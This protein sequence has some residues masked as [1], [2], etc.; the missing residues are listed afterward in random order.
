M[1]SAF[2]RR[3]TARP[4]SIP[5]AD[6]FRRST[7]CPAAATHRVPPE[8]TR[9]RRRPHTT[10][11]PAGKTPPNPLRPRVCSSGSPICSRIRKMKRRQTTRRRRPQPKR[12]PS[13]RRRKKLRF[14]LK[15][16]S[17]PDSIFK[18]Q[19]LFFPRPRCD[20]V[21]RACFCFGVDLAD[22]LPQKAHAKQLQTA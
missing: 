3:C 16:E 1:R 17:C 9:I 19:Y 2:R 8:V 22:I 11:I 21:A 7:S 12:L 14:L 13:R 18:N 4:T 5:K 20:D 15:T 10:A 6:V